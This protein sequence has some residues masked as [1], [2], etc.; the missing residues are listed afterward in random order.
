MENRCPIDLGNAVNIIHRLATGSPLTILRYEELFDFFSEEPPS[1]AIR[2]EKNDKNKLFEGILRIRIW[3]PKGECISWS[4]YS[5]EREKF[6][7]I[8]IRR[9]RWDLD[10][11]TEFAKKK[12][13]EKNKDLWKKNWEEALEMW[14]SI[15][16]CNMY[17]S[18]Q[19]SDDVI[20]L[21]QDFDMEIEEG[22]RLDNDNRQS[23]EWR[24]LEIKRKFD[25]GQIHLIWGVEKR[26]DCVEC[27][28]KELVSKLDCIINGINEN[29]FEM[30]LHYTM[31]PEDYKY[32]LKGN[33]D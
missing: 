17:I 29:I 16:V 28:I 1:I 27:K 11:D 10:K 3:R 14:P 4:I 12:L 8:I 24:E 26:N 5:E 33:K 31:N 7:S 20:R 19:Q 6:D 9:V 32:S 21:I 13:K 25:W 15:D 2:K 30:T 23:E 18:L 22:F